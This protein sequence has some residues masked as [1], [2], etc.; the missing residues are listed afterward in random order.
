MSRA[1]GKLLAD[2]LAVHGTEIAFCV[3]GESYLDL[4]DGLYGS[5]IRLIT[6]RHEASAANMAE[7]YGKLTGRP[8][9]CMVTRG[10]GATQAAVGVHTAFQ[11]STP[12]ILLVGQVSSTQE[13]RE[14]FQ[15]VDYRRMFGPLA[16]WVAQIDRVD[17]I[18]ELIARAYATA[19]SGRPGPVV[20]ALPEDMLAASSEAPDAPRFRRVQPSPA[21][22][23]IDALGDL[24]AGATRPFAIVGG[25]GWTPAAAAGLRTFLE[26]N[27]LPAGAA[28]RRQDAIDNDSPSYAGDVG[29]GI[30]PALAGRVR[31]ADLLLVVGPRLGE[32]TTSGYTLLD[33]PKPKQTLVHVHPGAEELGR[34]YQADLPILSGMEEFAAAVRDLRV[35]PAWGSATAEARREYEAWQRPEPMPGPVDLGEVVATLR[36]RVQ[37]AIVCN[38]AG[39]HT[40]WVHRFWRFHDYPS[41]LAPTSGAMGYGV[42][43]AVAA[44]AL[45]PDRDVICFSGDGDFLMSGQ[46]LATAVQYDLPIVVIVVDNGMYGTIRMHQERHFPGRVVGTDLV[47]PD[48]AAFA[49]AFGAHGETVERTE[50]FAGALERALDARVAAVIA[51]RIEP[52]AITPRTTLT[53]VRAAAEGAR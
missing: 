5:A 6:C 26:A 51:V 1:G 10:P 38:G 14:A 52:D 31:D 3:P 4:L 43:A 35:S 15:E 12:L 19:C 32:M 44:K 48:F 17:R 20:L 42:P 7:A 25:G 8:G 30:N 40:A 23:D 36:A 33:V 13:E 28:F 37:A 11:D 47:N 39:N 34:V 45:H 27:E 41:Q 46:E 50:D 9:V 53:A 21:R 24:L 2:Q 16:K 18:P 29:I 49:R 22:A